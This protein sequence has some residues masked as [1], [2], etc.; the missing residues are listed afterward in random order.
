MRRRLLSALAALAI[1]SASYAWG[2][3]KRITL[4]PGEQTV[5][6]VTALQ[7]IA[8]G[9]PSVVE[10]STLGDGREVL[11]VGRGLGRTNIILWNVEGR[12][13]TLEVTVVPAHLAKSASALRDLLKDVRGVEVKV[14]GDMLTVKGK[15]ATPGDFDRVDKAARTYGATNLVDPPPSLQPAVEDVIKQRLHEQGLAPREGDEAG[16]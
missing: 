1:F 6:E 11:I 12:R 7:R 3:D 9:D 8:V 2:A 16:R 5:L 15:V 10:A 14:V 13:Q 4:Y